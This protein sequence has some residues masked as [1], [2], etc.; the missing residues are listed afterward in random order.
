MCEPITFSKH[1]HVDS[2]VPCRGSSFWIFLFRSS[3]PLLLS[4]SLYI[5]HP[6]PS[7][8][9]YFNPAPSVLLESREFQLY[10]FFHQPPSHG[11]AKKPPCRDPGSRPWL[12]A[13]LQHL[14]SRKTDRCPPLTAATCPQEAC[15]ASCSS[16]CPWG[17]YLQVVI[18]KGL[19]PFSLG[20]SFS[21]LD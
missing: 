9:M 11:Q 16:S 13:I 6:A 1:V 20:A 7:F 21:K 19:L 4:F 18:R 3:M 14:R 8:Y 2:A 17:H 5:L 15:A 10:T 12:P